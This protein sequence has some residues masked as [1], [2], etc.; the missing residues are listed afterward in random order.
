VAHAKQVVAVAEGRETPYLR[1]GTRVPKGATVAQALKVAGLDWDVEL[2]PAAAIVDGKAVVADH[3][4]A[5]VRKDTNQVFDF[6]GQGY[7]AVQNAQ[8]LGI[9]DDLRAAAGV[10][11]V[12][13]GQQAGGRVV[14]VQV[15]LPVPLVVAGEDPY[16]MYGLV[17]TSHDGKRA[18]RFHITPLRLECLNQLNL[19]MAK[20]KQRWTIRHVAT[21]ESRLAEA[22]EAAGMVEAYAKEFD[23]TMQ[24]L[25][26]AKMTDKQMETFLT[27]LLPDRP[28][29][30]EEMS[31][32]T[33][34]AKD[35]PTNEFG[36]GTRYAALQAVREYFD[37]VRPQRTTESA[38]IGAVTGVNVK[39]ADRALNLLTR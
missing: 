12:C 19:A 29:R 14:W 22:H 2:M 10:D 38:L 30:P 34:L 13:A 9:A 33:T 28:K 35:S 37:H 16:D 23:A 7:A 21:A 11:F 39:T 1:H 27:T 5:V 26:K 36:R 24:G 15:K 20:A 6:V 32:I 8:G 18:V 3:R 31:A 4:F 17:E 25:L